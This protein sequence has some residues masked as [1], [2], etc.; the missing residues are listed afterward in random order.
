[1]RGTSATFPIHNTHTGEERM[2]GEGGGEGKKL[3]FAYVLNG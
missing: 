2:G 3:I 1:M